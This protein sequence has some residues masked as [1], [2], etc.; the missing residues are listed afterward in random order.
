MLRRCLI[1]GCLAAAAA[2]DARRSGNDVPDTTPA[3]AEPYHLDN[4]L[5]ARLLD[6]SDAQLSCAPGHP[7][8]A[9]LE[10]EMDVGRSLASHWHRADA[11]R[12]PRYLRM[13]VRYA[14]REPGEPGTHRR[15]I[16]SPYPVRSI[17]VAASL[18]RGLDDESG[19][20]I[21]EAT[22]LLT[23]RVDESAIRKLSAK[24]VE[25]VARRGNW[26]AILLLGRTGSREAERL[27]RKDERFR[28][29]PVRKTDLALAKLGDEAL[30]ARFID[31]YRKEPDP[32]KKWRLAHYGLAYIGS[33]LCCRALA[34]D[35]R[36]PLIVVGGNRSETSLRVWLVK[37]LHLALPDERV[38]RRPYRAPEDDS[39]YV[40]IEKWAEARYGIVWKRPRPPF[41]YFSRG[42]GKPLPPSRR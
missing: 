10:K 14:V 41:F 4:E 40:G 6:L 35:L 27:L 19:E 29:Y 36:T 5:L 13:M 33:D 31:E 21:G 30:Q 20:V 18:V 11:A 32:T 37:A 25:S 17:E 16:D 8:L 39:Y 24:I 23:E 12:R 1:L 42:I 7:A 38:L 34:E 22:R 26:H 28:R 9:P 15:F 2:C 3:E